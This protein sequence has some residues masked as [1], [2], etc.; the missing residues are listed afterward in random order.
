MSQTLN[1][2]KSEATFKVFNLGQHCA[3]RVELFHAFAHWEYHL[4]KAI[5]EEIIALETTNRERLGKKK[6][7]KTLVRTSDP[8]SIVELLEKRKVIEM[9]RPYILRVPRLIQLS[10]LERD[11]EYDI[12]CPKCRD[13]TT[14]RHRLIINSLIWQD[15]VFYRDHLLL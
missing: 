8:D 2:F 14:G 11:R 6:K 3:R 1:A 4:F 12:S 15:L 5:E 7:K 9:V 13:E 10:A